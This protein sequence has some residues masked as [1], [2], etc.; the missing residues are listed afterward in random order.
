M[1]AAGEPSEQW[2]LPVAHTAAAGWLCWDLASYTHAS[3]V[4]I[5]LSE[6][7]QTAPSP[8]MTN[9]ML[10]YSAPSKTWP[11]F[12][13]MAHMCSAEGESE[14]RCQWT[15]P[16][17]LSN[18]IA[19]L[20]SSKIQYK[21]QQGRLAGPISTAVLWKLVT[22]L[23]ILKSGTFSGYTE[24]PCWSATQYQ[25]GTTGDSQG[26]SQLMPLLSLVIISGNCVHFRIIF[27]QKFL[28]CL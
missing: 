11:C 3:Q 10:L 5:S 27:P 14:S 23:Q 18:T 20:I 15:V 19:S 6:R 13:R 16:V 12:W 8:L 2:Q 1:L 17:F 22:C 25:W 9:N 7:Q 4:P 28:C 24:V 26:P 21:Q